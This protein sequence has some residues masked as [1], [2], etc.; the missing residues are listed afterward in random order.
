MRRRARGEG[1]PA[2]GE[3]VDAGDG[4][5]SDRLA[6]GTSRRGFLARTSAW[7]VAAAGGGAA[8]EAG[9]EDAEAFHFCGHIYTTASCPHPNG[10]P[11]VDLRGYPLRAGDGRPIDDLGRPVDRAGFPLDERG[12]R[13][14]DPDGRPLPPAPRS[15]L[16]QEVV[17]ERYDLRTHVDGSWYRCCGGKVRRLVDCCAA[18]PR[19]INGDASLRGYCH[20][21]RRVFCV[22]YFQTQ[23]PC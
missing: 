20:G 18:H 1:E 9:V 10:L 2:G 3:A 8:L 16:C 5:V 14:R 17:A 4:R 11:R 12:R 15:R 13:L 7:L 19:R 21:D 6:A 22:M 23:V